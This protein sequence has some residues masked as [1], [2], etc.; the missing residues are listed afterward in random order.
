MHPLPRRVLRQLLADYGPALLDEP[1]RLDALLADHCGTFFRERF[2]LAHALRDRIPGELLTQSQAGS[3]NVQWLSQRLQRRY[4]LSAEAAQ[5]AIDCWSQGLN[6]APSIQ[7][8]SHNDTEIE[9]GIKI[10]LSDFPQG[11]LG[12]L[13]TEFG[14]TLLNDPLR[15]NALLAD[16]CNPHP[17]ERFL[18][19]HTLQEDI[20]VELLAQEQG[21]NDQEQRLSQHLQRRY[22]FHIEAVIWALRSWILALKVARSSQDLIATEA[23]RWTIES[24]SFALNAAQS[25]QDP[26]L[27]EDQEAAK[28]VA[29]HLA[30]EWNAARETARQKK[31]DLAA[32]ETVARQKVVDLDA[33]ETVV[34][35]NAVDL[36]AAREILRPKAQAAKIARQ[37]GEEVKEAIVQILK[38]NPLTPDEVG[39]IFGVSEEQAVTWLRQL[40]ESGTIEEILLRRPDHYPTGFQVK[41]WSYTTVVATNEEKRAAGV[42]AR[43]K[44]KEW[45]LAEP[46]ARKSERERA[47]AASRV[48]Q[49]AKERNS[50]VS[51]VQQI[52]KER[53]SAQTKTRQLAKECAAADSAAQQLSKKLAAAKKTVQQLSRKQDA[54]QM[55][56]RLK[57]KEWSSAA[58]VARKM[59]K[60]RTDAEAR[61][62]QTE[63][64]SVEIVLKNLKQNSLTS[65]EVAAILK[66]EQEQAIGLLKRLLSDNQIEITWSNRF[67]YAPCYQPVKPASTPTVSKD[68]SSPRPSGCM[69]LLALPELL[70][71]FALPG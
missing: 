64:R 32:A 53:N 11:V 43:Q 68:Q 63:K 69:W 18:L 25:G 40:E 62:R 3:I 8:P 41:G 31:N 55:E 57:A 26:S 5:W 58:E 9:N 35:Q 23:A 65:R 12:R 42:A 19:V 1:A 37:R 29:R 67:P 13:L 48:Q 59:V 4:C 66:I 61:A 56:A 44:V 15:V 28:A 71:L 22:G 27:E 47:A 20:P 34:R 52:A 6:V 39:K 38:L 70:G 60:K 24:W 17:A 30:T 54:A 50:A 2:L 10:S 7:N 14:P 51:K 45:K 46:D 16:F 36:T 33:A 21:D 49:L